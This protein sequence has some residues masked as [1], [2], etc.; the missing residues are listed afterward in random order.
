M[1]VTC[2]K[3]RPMLNASVNFFICYRKG[4]AANVHTQKYY[5]IYLHFHKCTATF[6]ILSCLEMFQLHLISL[7]LKL[8][9][10]ERTFSSFIHL[11]MLLRTTN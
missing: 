4:T 9:L 10:F 8:R 2:N 5:F 1:E 11:D 6:L 7:N 3:E